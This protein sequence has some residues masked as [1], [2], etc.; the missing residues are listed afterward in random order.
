MC[1]GASVDADRSVHPLL[2]AVNLANA[3]IAGFSRF[4][5]SPEVAELAQETANQLVT[6]SQQNLRKLTRTNAFTK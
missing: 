1:K 2:S 5:K 4:A 6:L 3:N